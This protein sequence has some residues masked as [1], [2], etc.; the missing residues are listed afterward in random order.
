MTG[1]L[2]LVNLNQISAYPNPFSSLITLQWQQTDL[3]GTQI[4]LRDGT[5]RIIRKQMITASSSYDKSLTLNNLEDFS[6]GIYFIELIQGD[7]H[8]TVKIMK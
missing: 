6:S 3:T 4:V 5:G 8:A 2:D 7:E 1:I